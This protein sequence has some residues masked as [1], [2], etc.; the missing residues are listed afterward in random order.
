MKGDVDMAEN[1]DMKIT[2]EESENGQFE[3]TSYE[4]K[5]DK[6]SFGLV[7]T[8]VVEKIE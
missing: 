2:T 7:D 6:E 4:T 5:N 3:E 1:N 8:V